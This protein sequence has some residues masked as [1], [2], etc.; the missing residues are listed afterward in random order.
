[1]TTEA[2]DVEKVIRE[3]AAMDSMASEILSDKQKV[4]NTHCTIRTCTPQNLCKLCRIYQ[5]SIYI[6][7]TEVAIN[8]FRSLILM[9]R[10]TR[11][12]KLYGN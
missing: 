1:M 8:N 6:S 3:Y 7:F 4:I 9:P 5:L 10:G 12:E 2:S 11:E